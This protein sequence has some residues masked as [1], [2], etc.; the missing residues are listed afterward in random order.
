MI[1]I[2]E[3]DGRISEEITAVCADVS[4]FFKVN[5]AEYF[6]PKGGGIPGFLDSAFSQNDLKVNTFIIFHEEVLILILIWTTKTLVKL[7]K[8][9]H[10]Y[11]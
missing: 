6:H 5:K 3:S 7:N 9:R 1:D 8:L 2:L 11:I 10:K 4:I